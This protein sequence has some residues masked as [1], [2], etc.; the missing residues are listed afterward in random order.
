MPAPHSTCRVRAM[1]VSEQNPLIDFIFKVGKVFYAVQVTI[2]KTHDAEKA[3][4]DELVRDLKLRKGEELK[5]LYAV[6]LDHFEMFDTNPRKPSIRACPVTVIG[7]PNPS[8]S[9]AAGSSTGAALSPAPLALL[10][11]STVAPP[12]AA[13]STNDARNARAA[14]R[15][16]GKK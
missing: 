3:K 14:N 13:T 4:I 1:P 9:T 15:T 7:I 2:G 10:A 6:P 8:A 12:P 5:L 11:G 16:T